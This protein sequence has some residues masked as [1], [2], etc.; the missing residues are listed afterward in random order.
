M[1]CEHGFT[2]SWDCP[3]CDCAGCGRAQAECTCHQ[4]QEASRLEDLERVRL[5]AGEV[6]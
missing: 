4:D 1:L 3:H 5:A 2:A 6:A